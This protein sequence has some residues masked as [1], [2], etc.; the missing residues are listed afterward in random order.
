MTVEAA[1]P[2]ETQPP[3]CA[4]AYGDLGRDQPKKCEHHLMHARSV[5]SQ[6]PTKRHDLV[7]QRAPIRLARIGNVHVYPERPAEWAKF[8]RPS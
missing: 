4:R 3:S 1:R 5:F 6:P 7:G 2:S 8:R